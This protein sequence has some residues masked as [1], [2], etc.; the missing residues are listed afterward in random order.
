MLKEATSRYFAS[1]FAPNKTIVK[2]KDTTKCTEDKK[3]AKDVIRNKEGSRMLKDGE[4]RLTRI[5]ND[6]F[7]Y[8]G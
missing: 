1:G 7:E 8:L 6:K 3:N 2:L 5:A 4:L